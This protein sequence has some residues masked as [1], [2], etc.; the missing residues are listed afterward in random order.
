MET[1][2]MEKETLKMNMVM[3]NIK[4]LMLLNMEILK[5]TNMLEIKN[6]QSGWRR[7]TGLL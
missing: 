5:K 7:R 4:M 6:K 2:K 1:I 3:M